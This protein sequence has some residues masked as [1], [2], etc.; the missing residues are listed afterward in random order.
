L[1]FDSANSATQEPLRILV[2]ERQ[3]AARMPKLPEWID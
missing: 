3:L 1:G 2:S